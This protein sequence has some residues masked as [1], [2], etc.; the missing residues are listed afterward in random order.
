MEF[1]IIF[2][3]MYVL[4]YLFWKI[5]EYFYYKSK[6]FISIKKKIQDYV[7]EC[8]QLNNHIENLKNTPL[9]CNQL[10][11]GV[12]SYSDNSI[13]N[14]SRPK[15]KNIKF[16]PYIHNC[17]RTVCDNA[18]KQP[19]KYI[20]KYFNIKANEETLSAWENVLNNYNALENGKK[21]LKQQKSDIM[22]AIKK[23]ISL[24]IRLFSK[25]LDKKLGF[26]E[27]DFKTI[28]FPTYIFNYVSSGGYASTRCEII[29]DLDNLNR[30][31]IY[32]SNLVKFKKSVQGQRALMT[33][34]LRNHILKRDN[35]TCKICELSSNTEKNLLLEV[36]HIV[37]LSKGGITSETNLQ[38][39]CWKCNRKKSNKI[40]S[41]D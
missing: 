38:T 6:A 37:P 21:V 13:Y 1:F 15:Y 32:L 22:K 10:D 36:D 35:Y 19:F 12:S 7:E 8:N 26:N 25:K 28:Y 4:I 17:S 24:F 9:S 33:S 14:Y 23:D 27:I 40:Q 5:Y 29:L 11:Y 20:C 41:R 31:V 2:A 16:A 34:R 30:F 3:L 39:L 18:R